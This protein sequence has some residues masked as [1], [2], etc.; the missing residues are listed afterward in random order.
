MSRFSSRVVMRQPQ[1]GVTL[2]E[3]MIVLAVI[4][5]ATG[6]LTLGLG[7]L[8]RDNRAEQEA[9]RL[10]D[11]ISLGVDDALISGEGRWVAWDAAGYTIGAM[12][13]HLL[14]SP[15]ALARADGETAPVEL[16][17]D[18]TSLAV[19]FVLQGGGAVWRVSFDGMSAIVVP[20]DVP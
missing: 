3:M 20:G 17:A 15:V 12:A 6:A 13:P 7:A 9:R 8:G 4:G 14:A 11:A 18:A 19:D 5:V 2:I 16:T 1:A 10:A